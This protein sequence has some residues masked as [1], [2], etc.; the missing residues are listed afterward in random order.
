MV[1]TAAA[2][3]DNYVCKLLKYEKVR[4][5]KMKRP[6]PLG[7]RF[8]NLSIVADTRGNTSKMQSVLRPPSLH[9]LIDRVCLGQYIDT[10]ATTKKFRCFRP[11]NQLKY[12]PYAHDF[13]PFN[14][15]CVARFIVML[16]QDLVEFP[17]CKI[18]YC[19]DPVVES[20]PTQLSFWAL[21]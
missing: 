11:Q 6:H 20:S 19:V 5:I 1:C 14:F 16:D 7:W 17:S 15:D 21:T 4:F 10:F 13:G 3:R 12:R 9:E 8:N 2:F 18:V